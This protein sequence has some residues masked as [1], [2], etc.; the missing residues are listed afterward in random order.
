MKF[1]ASVKDLT[2]PLTLAAAPAATLERAR[3]ISAVLEAIRLTATGDAVEIA[4]NILDFSL[5]LAAPATIEAPGLIAVPGQ[6]LAALVAGFPGNA[7]VTIATD[8]TTANVTCGRSRFRLPVIPSDQMPAPLALA[9]ET[10][11]IELSRVDALKALGTPLPAVGTEATRYHLTGVYLHT[12][13]GAL[14][15]VGCDGTRLVRIL[16]PG[17]DGFAAG[18]IVPRPAV[19]IALKLLAD[20][21]IDRIMLCRSAT[22]FALDG[23]HFVFIS[24]VIDGTYP[25]YQ[26]IVPVLSGNAVSVSRGA[27]LAALERVSAVADEALP[28]IVGLQWN[29][30]A[31]ALRLCLSQQPGI[32]NDAVDAEVF[33]VG[34]VAVKIRLLAELLD[35]LASKRVRLDIDGAAG[36]LVICDPDDANYLAVLSPCAWINHHEEEE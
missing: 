33:G 22:L 26:R 21:T 6:R 25:H 1:A 10:G 8:G 31:P 32:A 29:A 14:A 7:T 30:N 20:K 36:P 18:V 15:A 11:R 34:R 3:K 35:E 9:E 2:Q 16:F 17:V 13:D 5:A 23:P 24:K 28:M 27:L 19:K 4:G 12:A